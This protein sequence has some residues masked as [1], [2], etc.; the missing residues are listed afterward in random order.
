[1]KKAKKSN[2]YTNSNKNDNPK[3]DNI[4][5]NT[6]DHKKIWEYIYKVERNVIMALVD[7]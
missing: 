2:N 7:I 6:N 5:I 4:N 1:M 3:N